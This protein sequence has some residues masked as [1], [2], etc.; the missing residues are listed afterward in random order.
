MPVE[1]LLALSSDNANVMVGKKNSMSMVLREVQPAL[2][3][4]GCPCHLINLAA[5]KG[6][7]CLPVKVDEAL[8]DIFFHLKKSVKR[9]D[10]LK[11]LQQMHDVEVRMMLKHSP[12]RWLL[13]GKC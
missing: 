6:A 12:T 1:N 3:G 13:L 10:R 11:E 8:I 2:I 7:S 9:K 4:V 5:Q